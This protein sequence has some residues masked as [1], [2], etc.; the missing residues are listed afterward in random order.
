MSSRKNT[1]LKKAK[2]ETNKKKWEETRWRRTG[3]IAQRW[4]TWRPEVEE[5]RWWM[6]KEFDERTNEGKRSKTL[7]WAVC[8]LDHTSGFK[9]KAWEGQ[10]LPLVQGRRHQSRC[11]CC[12]RGCL[13]YP[14]A[15]LPASCWG[16]ETQRGAGRQ[17][18]ERA[19]ESQV[20]SVKALLMLTQWGLVRSLVIF[21]I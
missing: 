16:A 12:G 2:L 20:L 14:A 3:Q 11:R 18:R 4:V 1:K 19:N 10:R 15:R 6:T 9:S 8:R 5:I 7:G 13:L 21:Y 17:T